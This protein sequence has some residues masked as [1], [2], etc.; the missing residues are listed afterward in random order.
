MAKTLVVVE[1]PAK[2]K[3]IGG[4]LGKG[5]TV[6]ASVG[7][8]R[9]L[10]ADTLAVDIEHGFAPTYQISKG[11]SEVVQEIAAA[12]KG[13]TAIYLATD[14][15][16]EG[17]AIAWHVAAAAGL[18]PAKTQ[19]VTFHQVTKAAIQ[20][21]IAH[22]R[23]LDLHL[24]DAQQAR[25]VLDRLVGY[26]ISP[27][28]SK[29]L[30]RA[31]SAGRVQSVALR[32]VVERER[33]I[34]AFVPEE[35]WSLEADLKRRTPER[36]VFRAHLHK[37]AGQDPALQK[38]AD[39]ERILIALEGATY[40]VSKAQ[41]GQ[42]QDSPPPPFITSTLQAEAGRKLRFSPRQTMRFAQELYEGIQLGE[43]TVGL[44]TYMRT[45]STNVAPEAQAEA[46]EFIAA[47]WGQE[48]VPA[49]PPVYRRKVALAQEAHEAIRPTSVQRT[50]EAMRPHLTE[51]Q[52][53]LYE[54]IWRRFLASQMCPALYE[55]LTV[56]I[57]AARDYLFRA[58]GAT[59]RF[60]GYL[61]VYSEGRDD[62]EEEKAQPLPPLTVGEVVDLLKLLPEQHFTKPPPRY[63]EP[64][65]IKALEENGVGRP[66]TY[67]AIVG[68]IQERDYVVK[69][70]GK[71]AP[72]ALGMIVCDTL[73]DTF[74][75]VMDIGY[76][77]AME[78]QLDEVA[79][80]QVT[81][82][83]MLG[84]FYEGFRPQLEAARGHM[85]QAVE[86]ALWAG[87]PEAL[88]E[89]TCPQCGKPLQIRLSETGRFMGC[90]GYPEC[91]YLLDL[92]APDKPAEPVA[93][94]AE[95]ETCEKCGGRMKIIT[96]GKD[97]F[98][99]CEN[100]PRCKSTRPILSEEIQRLAAETACP[101][102]GLKPLQP[103]KGRFGE[104][105]RC[106]QCQANYSLRALGLAA[107]KGTAPRA[108]TPAEEVPIAC[109]ECNH[110][111]LKKIAGRYGPYYR[112]SKCKTNYSEK[113]LAARLGT[114][115]SD[116]SS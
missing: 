103:S 50:P 51:Q 79:A 56:E 104:Y 110:P 68:V 98:L 9:D 27:L 97:R 59:L 65:L 80:G 106:P 60:P 73:V 112:C 5:Y 61:A 12:A 19:R 34:L 26:Q 13:A 57:L 102:C 22:P 41:A 30:R 37:V 53:R 33:E 74:T 47:R 64:T 31:L 58:T 86:K 108:S 70:Q 94:F 43:E 1:S 77:A 114:V 48:Y 100:Y 71:L 109:P 23:A 14:P 38:Q 78:G 45:D 87:L 2:A 69:T 3:T 62:E 11:K 72:T 8:V 84:R 29:T 116:S 6:K 76:T 15:D 46:R 4:Y 39:V 107:K 105:L 20:E 83:V 90:T 17:E 16:R 81:Y 113:K 42:R 44:I 35:Y 75:E 52:A 40:T 89:R 88:R 101:T 55:T 21:A 28:L 91:R 7:H 111:T 32:M 67:A 66:S 24:I 25:R 92:S 49:K 82:T 85:P 96:R 54:L 18:P 10:P 93:E 95:G 36:E 63:S 115:P 99:G